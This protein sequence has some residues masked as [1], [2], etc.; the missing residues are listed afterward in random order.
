MKKLHLHATSEIDE[1][2]YPQDNKSLSIA[3]PALEFFTDFKEV[4]P[5]LISASMPAVEALKL[6]IQNHVRFKFVVDGDGH[7]IGVVSADD[8]VERKIVMKVSEGYVRE[9][10]PVSDFMTDKKMMKALDFQEIAAAQ[11]SDV[12]AVLKQS[13]QQHCLVIDQKT[14][15][16]RGIFSASDIS[17]KLRLPIDI[18]EASSFYRVFSATA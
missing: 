6:M 7:F 15:K 11:I 10:I 3:S 14:H 4:K 1:L 9:V 17:R 13:G 5:L 2:E 16:V 12:I 18:Q 8:L